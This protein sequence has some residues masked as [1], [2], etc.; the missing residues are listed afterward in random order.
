L[1]SIF[2]WMKAPIWLN[3]QLLLVSEAA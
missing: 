2:G 3:A 1:Q